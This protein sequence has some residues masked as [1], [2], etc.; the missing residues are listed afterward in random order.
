MDIPPGSVPPL[1]LTFK[2][3]AGTGHGGSAV[4]PAFGRLRQED[5]FW[6]PTADIGRDSVT[7]G[8]RTKEKER[9]EGSLK[10][11]CTGFGT[12]VL[13]IKSIYLSIH[14]FMHLWG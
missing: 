6:R 8:G 2:S 5:Q 4:I 10:A 3:Q 7:T 13:C 9:K 12:S 11:F 1:K 14:L